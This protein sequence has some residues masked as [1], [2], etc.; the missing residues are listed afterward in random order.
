[1]RTILSLL[2]ILLVGCELPSEYYASSATGNT[3]HEKRWGQLGGTRSNSRSDG[4]SEANNYENSFRDG[5]T[6]VL[7]YGLAKVTGGVQNVTTRND[8]ARAANA[9]TPTVTQP[10][11]MAPDTTVFPIVT[12]PAKSVIP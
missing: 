8:T 12:P 5:S 10:A 4:S 2:S 11:Q 6:A 7:S 1:M 9:R 3:V